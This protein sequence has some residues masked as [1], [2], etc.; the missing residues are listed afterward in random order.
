[1]NEKGRGGVGRK[2]HISLVSTVGAGVPPP[3][4]P[5][6]SCPIQMGM[7]NGLVFPL[8]PWFPGTLPH[9]TQRDCRLDVVIG[10]GNLCRV[11]ILLI[12]QE[13]VGCPTAGTVSLGLR[14][15]P[16]M[17]IVSARVTLRP[18]KG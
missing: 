1:M 12:F 13:H 17:A 8:I 10:M 7:I 2:L 18:S 14:P 6:H 5:W 11:Q 3:L 15:G 4:C 9:L 16:I